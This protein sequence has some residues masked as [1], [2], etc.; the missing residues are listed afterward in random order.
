MTQKFGFPPSIRSDGR[1]LN[2][3]KL[4]DYLTSIRF[5]HMVRSSYSPK[6]N[7]MSKH[8]GQQIKTVLDKCR[9]RAGYLRLGERVEV[10]T[11]L[12][13]ICFN[14]LTGFDEL[15]QYINPQNKGVRIYFSLS[16][17]TASAQ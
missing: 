13:V 12:L 1:P 9:N 6:S 11:S 5:Q 8:R 14:V 3:S 10:A 7:V 16:I 15:L 4:S 17:L 2:T